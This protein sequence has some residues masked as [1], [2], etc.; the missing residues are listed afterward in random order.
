MRDHE[1]AALA[2]IRAAYEE[3]VIYTGAGLDGETIMAIP[4]DSAALPFQGPGST[5]REVSFEIAQALL[6]EEPR[7][8]NLLQHG[9]NHWSVIDITQRDDVAA[10]LLV[11]EEAQP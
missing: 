10:W 9:A 3:P 2:D 1:A 5:A 11:V 6:S 4:S 8:G 7:N